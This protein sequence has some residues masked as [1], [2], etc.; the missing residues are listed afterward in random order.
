ML[1]CCLVTDGGGALILTSADRAKDFPTKPV[2]ILGTGE[3]VETPMISQMR[4]FTS[5]AAFNSASNAEGN[6]PP[7][8]TL[9]ALPLLGGEGWGEGEPHLI[10]HD[11]KMWPLHY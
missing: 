8:M 1:M 3:S 5:S 10:I 9:A 7:P 6:V 2:Y 4:D 11:E